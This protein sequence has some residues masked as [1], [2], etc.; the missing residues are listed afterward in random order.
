[1]NSRDFII[2]MEPQFNMEIFIFPARGDVSES[3]QIEYLRQ[4][5]IQGQMDSE[6]WV[7]LRPEFWPDFID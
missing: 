6:F 3:I 1:M 4:Y 7:N 2:G 5:S